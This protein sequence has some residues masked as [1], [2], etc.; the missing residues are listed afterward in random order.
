MKIKEQMKLK[1]LMGYFECDNALAEELHTRQVELQDAVTP[2]QFE[3]DLDRAM[4]RAGVRPEIL[5]AAKESVEYED[6]MAKMVSE[7]TGIIGRWDMADKIDT[8]SAA[9]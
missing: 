5:E 1:M 6:A 9:A 8:G 7:L 4:L 3:A 2:A